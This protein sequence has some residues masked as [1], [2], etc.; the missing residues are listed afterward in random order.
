FRF[1]LDGSAAVRYFSYVSMIIP[2]NDAFIAN[3]PPTAHRVFDTSGEFT[4][5]SFIVYGIGGVND[6]G[7][8]VN[9]EIPAN[10]A[11]FGQ[12]APDTGVVEGGVVTTH[13]GF[14]PAGSGGI[15]DDPRFAAATFE[16]P[17][18]Q[19]ARISVEAVR[20]T[21]IA[22]GASAAQEVPTNG[23]T[24]IAACE[25]RLNADRNAFEL[26][27]NHEVDDASAAHIHI[28]APG[29]NGPVVFDLGDPAS[30]IRAT[31]TDLTQADVDALL[32]GGLYVN[33]H[34]PTYPGGEIRGQ[35]AGCFAGPDS[36][37]LNDQRFQVEVDWQTAGE[38]GIGKSIEVREDT[39]LFYFFSE[40]NIELAV[41][42]LDGCDIN[43][44][45][46]VFAGGLTDQGVDITVTDTLTGQVQ[47]YSNELGT[48]FEPIRDTSAFATCP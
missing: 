14:L 8:E 13:P 17:G 43:G 6:G 10:T 36:L 28:G 44:Y 29:E 25:G 47:T 24:A 39:G 42:V 5:V 35:I 16:R 26:E 23:S 33:I 11:F 18:Y 46:W 21:E 48:A 2:S 4:P 1:N 3:G 7:T 34:S 12:A 22:F 37:C 19:I 27:C 40:P 15:L 31:W 20:G 41:K 45:Y 9:D 38:N 32:T 30:P